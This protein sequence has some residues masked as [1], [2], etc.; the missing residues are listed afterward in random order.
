MSE[1]NE[2]MERAWAIESILDTVLPILINGSPHRDLALAA[3][4][5]LA[6]P[7]NDQS[8]YP[9]DQVAAELAQSLLQ[10]IQ[11]P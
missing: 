4:A 3:L 5:D 9:E 2:A 6:K 1:P 11:A 10:R 8:P 7:E